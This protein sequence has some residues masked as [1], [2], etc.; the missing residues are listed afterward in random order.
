M[1][2]LA[3]DSV[4]KEAIVDF[5]KRQRKKV[6]WGGIFINFIIFLVKFNNKYNRIYV[7]LSP[8][9]TK[10]DQYWWDFWVVG[11]N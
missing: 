10:G 2:K 1:Q 11:V 9:I 6:E 5:K 8:Q 3:A 7:S 4:R